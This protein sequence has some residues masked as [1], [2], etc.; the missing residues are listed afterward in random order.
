MAKASR[1]ARALRDLQPRGPSRD[2]IGLQPGVSS[3]TGGGGEKRRARSRRHCDHAACVP[4]RPASP[5]F[6][7]AAI[8]RISKTMNARYR[9][10]ALAASIVCLTGGCPHGK[11]TI[12][13][14]V[15]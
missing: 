8:A 6:G 1:G 5:G 11:H 3:F 14:R 12:C 9:L 4:L 2:A 15:E 10:F 13:K 7:A